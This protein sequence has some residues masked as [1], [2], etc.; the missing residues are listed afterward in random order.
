MNPAPNPAPHAP[1]AE[2]QTSR[3]PVPVWSFI[4]L[5]I[6]LYWGFV[7]FDLHGGWFNT[8][9]YAPYK[10][11]AELQFY[12]PPPPEGPEAVI[13]NGRRVYESATGCGLCHNTDGLGKPGQAPP[14][15]GSEW[16]LGSP[17]RMIRIPLAGLSGPITVA[18]QQ[19]NLSMPAIGATLSDEDLANVLSYIRNSWGN[20]VSLITPQQVHAV[21][22]E[23]GNRSQPWS[24]GELLAVPEK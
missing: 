7:Y 23:I 19:Y 17:A 11:F 10:S 15:V 3:R 21:K 24:A 2:P 14:F 9:V 6:L 8:Q 13:A 5:F 22:T 20:K 12:Q 18:G 1:D 4:L 16:V